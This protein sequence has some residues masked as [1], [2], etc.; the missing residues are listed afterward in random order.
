MTILYIVGAIFLF[1]M[2]LWMHYLA[3]MNL[4]R[5]EAILTIPA[6][7]VGYPILGVGYVLDFIWNII[8]SIFFLEPP[9]SWLFTGRVQYHI[10]SDT[11]KGIQARWWCRHFIDSFDPDGSHC[12]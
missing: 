6:K 10:A 11:W 7:I 9:R 5:H 1:F 3:V 8:S 2:Q 4:K 12:T